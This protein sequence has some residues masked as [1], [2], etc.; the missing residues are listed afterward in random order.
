MSV[1]Y[2]KFW[3]V[4]H[5]QDIS[6]VFDLFNVPVVETHKKIIA[7]PQKGRSTDEVSTLLLAEKREKNNSRAL[8]RYFD[9]CQR[10]VRIIQH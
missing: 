3:L 8:F 10:Q 1:F 4:S 7:P 5:E 2:E 9:V 6:A